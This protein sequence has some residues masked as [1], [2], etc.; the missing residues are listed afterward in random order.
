[1]GSPPD[2][3]E[4]AV[5]GAGQDDIK[6]LRNRMVGTPTMTGE[7]GTPEEW[8]PTATEFLTGVAGHTS[9]GSGAYYTNYFRQCHARYIESGCR[10]CVFLV[11]LRIE[12]AGSGVSTLRLST[13][14][15][16]WAMRPRSVGC[17][18]T[19]DFW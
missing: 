11:I 16:Q 13:S 9:N 2:R 12:H 15:R 10:V 14:A 3:P 17:T 7:H 19:P 6:L 4:L 1:M 5:L 8:S 18:S